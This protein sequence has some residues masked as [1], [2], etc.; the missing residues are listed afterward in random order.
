MMAAVLSA[1]LAIAAL[2]TRPLPEGTQL[3]IRLTTTVGSYASKPGS[4]VSA[5]LIAPVTMDGETVLPSGSTLSGRVK[6]VTRVGFG[7]RHETAGL[8]LEFNQLTPLD[9]DAVPVSAQVAEVDN[10]RERVTRDGRIQGVRST[11]SICY[12]VSGYIRTLL[13]WEVHAELATWAIRSLI[14]QVPE[15][16]I[17]YPAGVELTLALTQPLSLNVPLDVPLNSWQQA[18]GQLT[19]DEREELTRDVAAM[20]YRTQAPAS[21]RSSDLTNLLFIGTQDQIAAAFA[22]AGWTQADPA[23]MRGR[24]NWLRAVAELRGDGVAPMSLLLLNGADPDMSWQKGLN[25]VSKRHHIRMWKEDTTW[26]GRDMWVGAATRDI[27]FAYLRRGGKLSHKIDED[28][29]RERDKVAYDLAFT[30]CGNVLDWTERTDFPR[31]ASNATGDPIVTDGRMVVI[32]LNDCQAPRLSTETIDRTPVPEHG[33]KLQRFARRE[34][35]SARNEL[36]RQNPYWRTYEG[37]RWLVE[38]IRRRRR[39]TS[40][41]ELASKSPSSGFFQSVRLAAARMQ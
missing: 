15:P 25:D 32:E 1:L 38:W 22:A 31:S 14:A 13:L 6:A 28:V 8:D 39:E 7:V 11:G 19:G 17:Y 34:V 21:G 20:P 33:D 16:E 12:R 5:V 2:T 27:D 4:P 10:S 29:D 18:A 9:G 24:I 40:G 36:L 3:H 35:L 37:S 26:H 41:P 30:S 23:S